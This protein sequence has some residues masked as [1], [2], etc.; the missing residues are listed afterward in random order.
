M[1][2]AASTDD[3][4]RLVEMGRRFFAETGFSVVAE[5]DDE[6]FARTLTGLI[7][8]ENGAVFVAEEGEIIG[9]IGGMVY[10]Q[11]FNAAHTTGQEF[12]LWCDREHRKGAGR[13]LLKALENWARNQGARSFTMVALDSNR[14]EA[15]AAMYRR[16]GYQPSE[17]NFIRKL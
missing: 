12:F 3:T 7:E 8:G 11:F 17:R 15:V 13:K 6:S 10:P 5:F 1:I 16:A 14:P 9:F 4:P 2:R